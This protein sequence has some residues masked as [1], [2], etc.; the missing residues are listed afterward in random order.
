M[1]FLLNK[2]T[3]IGSLLITDNK[4][5]RNGMRLKFGMDIPQRTYAN[6]EKM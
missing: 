3:L 1:H 5:K 2:E 4:T 6:C